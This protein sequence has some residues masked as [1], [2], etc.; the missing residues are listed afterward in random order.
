MSAIYKAFND[1]EIACNT[2]AVQDSGCSGTPQY[3]PQVVTVTPL[4]MG[5]LISWTPV[6]GAS[7]YQVFRTEGVKKCGQGKVKLAT[8]TSLSFTDSNL[9]NGREYYYIVIPKG[10]NDSCF[11][12]ASGCK[13]IIPTEVPPPTPSPSKK[14][15]PLPTTVPTHSPTT[16]PTNRP[17]I[18]CTVITAEGDCIVQSSCVWRPVLAQCR[19][20]FRAGKTAKRRLQ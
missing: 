7:N 11:G 15:S 2:I 20:M 5:A 6:G 14:P 12:P 18:D 13:S 3:P 4:N 16:H 19:N 10:P 17:T 9:M 1:Q 8:T